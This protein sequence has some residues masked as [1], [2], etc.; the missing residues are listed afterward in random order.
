MSSN[1]A[2][3][4]VHAGI[5][6]QSRLPLVLHRVIPS[7]SLTLHTIGMIEAALIANLIYIYGLRGNS[8]APLDAMTEIAL[9]MA[10]GA[11][12]YHMAPP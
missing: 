3:A 2:P 12:L 4:S 10:V 8:I 9:P 7:G 11:G 5:F 6:V 1:G